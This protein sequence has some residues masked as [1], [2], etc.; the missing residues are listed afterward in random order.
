MVRIGARAALAR[1]ARVQNFG[2]ENQKV[3][4]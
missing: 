4:P 3:E 2:S 1:D